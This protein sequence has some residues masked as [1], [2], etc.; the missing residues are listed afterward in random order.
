MASAFDRFDTLP[1]SRTPLIGRERE[2]DVVSDLLRRDDVPL[3]T[4]TGPGGVG[5]TRLALQVAAGLGDAFP[6]GVRFVGLA[7]ISDPGLVPATIAQS[8]GMRETGTE[9]LTARL[10]AHLR[11]KRLLL[12]LDN[13]EQVVK[14]APLV[15]ELLSACPSLTVLVTSR[16]RLR[17][18]GEREHAVPPLGLVVDDEGATV[19]GVARS[20]AAQLFVA[21][22][23]AVQEEF[24]L[25][26]EQAPA[27]LAI[28]RRLDGLPLAIE[29]AAAWIKVLPPPA[30]LARL[31]HRLPLLTGGARDLPP[32]QQ[33]M[34]DAIAWS[35][36]LLS[37]EQ[38]GL[39]RRLSVFVGG[40]TLEAAEAV[41][42][43][44]AAAGITVFE[45]IASLVDSSLVRQAEGVTGE[46]RFLMLETVREYGWERLVASGEEATIRGQHAAWYVE[47][48]RRSWNDLRVVAQSGNIELLE[49][50]RAN[51]REAL[52]WLQRTGNGDDLLGLAAT[53]GF[54]W[55]VAGNYREGQEWLERALVTGRDGSPYDRVEAL[56]R[57][58]H[59][60][61]MLG[62]H[63]GAM[64]RLHEAALL[65]HR[66]GEASQEANALVFLGVV[67]EDRGDYDRAKEQFM[68]ALDLYT[69]AGDAH[70]QRI[71]EVTY[72]LGVVAYGQCDIARAEALLEE[73]QIAARTL[74]AVLPVAWCLVYLG[75]LHIE[76]DDMAAAARALRES[77]T[78]SRDGRMP[79]HE[80]QVL[81]AVAVLAC[82]CG[83]IEAAAR[84]QG[85]SAA[86]D[87]A[88]GRTQPDDFPE[89]TA[90][91]RTERLLREALGESTYARAWE[92]GRT[93]RPA[94]VIGLVE[95]VFDIAEARSMPSTVDRGITV[96]TPREREVLCLLVAGRS[97]P[98]IA[99]TLFVSTRTITTH[100]EH[101]FAKLGVNPRAEA[102]T[103]AARADLCSAPS[104]R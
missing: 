5:K 83:E 7:P 103:Q 59:L 28:C 23:Q 81:A 53:L 33:T 62:D 18:S 65:A 69:T 14:A 31:E 55:Y 1:L 47:F 27:V 29:L 91:E 35:Y 12:V 95:A 21:R 17:V 99:R 56:C 89:R 25:T 40:F 78:L 63:D 4:L 97:N 22:V 102:A 37:P 70:P 2:A 92:E 48:G 42:T 54:F 9:Q 100:V 50:E 10:T 66:L 93:M 101:I 79:H 67:D 96:L 98:E 39:F 72:H 60:A 24:A 57:A 26:D 58:G 8:L 32:R 104:N 90:Y 38:Q 74:G 30:M 64:A 15:V 41:A 46:P 84:L 11:E 44:S 82:A 6:D 13:F 73:A 71:V 52:S 87:A 85:G 61:H 19:D 43:P 16:V 86:V 34:R 20:D 75:L 88:H 80:G 51:L 77:A 49:T 68:A 94:D 36:D 45:G 76:R 3:V